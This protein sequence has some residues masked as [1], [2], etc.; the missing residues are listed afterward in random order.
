MSLSTRVILDRIVELHG[1][2]AWPT[3]RIPM[4]ALGLYQSV[5]VHVCLQCVCV[6]VCM[7]VYVHAYCDGCLL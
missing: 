2:G 6:C 4:T 7:C 5:C 3:T 1:A